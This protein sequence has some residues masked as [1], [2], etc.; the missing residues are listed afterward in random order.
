MIYFW[1]IFLILCSI[2]GAYFAKL[3]NIHVPY[4][5]WGVFVC[6]LVNAF[7]WVWVTKISQNLLFDSML[8]DVVMMVTFSVCLILLKCGEFFTFLNWVGLI[9]TMLGLILMKI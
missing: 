5:G 7:V 4:S 9:L 6:C 2:G 8:F 3:S 1:V